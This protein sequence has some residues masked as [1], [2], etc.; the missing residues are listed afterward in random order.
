MPQRSPETSIKRIGLLTS[1]S[2]CSG[3]NAVIR[4][5]VYRA[6]Q[7]YG[8]Q[9]FGIQRGT[10]GLMERP[11]MYGELNMGRF[12]GHMLRTGGTMLGASSKGDSFHFPIPDGS[13]KDQ[14]NEFVKGF[15]ETAGTLGIYLGEN[16][17]HPTAE[18]TS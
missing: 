10:L 13:F 18:S 8:W 6:T 7:T 12:Q 1:G 14:S 2:D 17:I 9:V 4:A 16:E 3:L 15:L 11:L 5:V